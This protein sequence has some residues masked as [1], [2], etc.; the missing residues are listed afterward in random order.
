[1]PNV[2]NKALVIERIAARLK[3]KQPL[4]SGYV[5]THCVPLYQASC[6]YFGSWRKSIEASGIAYDDV[7]ITT[8]SARVWS[9]KKIIASIRKRKHLKL[10]LNSNSVQISQPSLYQAALRYFGGWSQA[11]TAAGFDYV[12]LRKQKPK[13]AWSKTSIVQEIRR[14]KKVGLSIRGGE[15]AVDDGGLYTATMRHFGENGW[16]KA[17][18]SAGF[19]STDSSPLKKW[20]RTTVCKEIKRLSKLG[21]P[22]HVFALVKS[23]F[24]YILGAGRK[25]FGSWKK[26]INAAGLN[27]SK[28]RKVCIGYWTKPRIIKHIKILEKKGIRLNHKTIREKGHGAL[29]GAAITRFGCWSNAVEAAGISYKRHCLIWSTKAWIRRMSPQDIKETIRKSEK[30][31]KIRRNKNKKTIHEGII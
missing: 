18:V 10:P 31:S 4:N 16:S 11:I 15:V 2:W 1:M 8:R 17:R 14:R 21:V 30:G 13:R 5:Q 12:K 7:R 28:I 26:A 24:S 23:E 9:S 19:K 25:V 22:L 6:K 3:R 29:L 27:Y 20:D